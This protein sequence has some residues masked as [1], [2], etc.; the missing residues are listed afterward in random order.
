MNTTRATQQSDNSCPCLHYH[1][2]IHAGSVQ[3]AARHGPALSGDTYTGSYHSEGDLASQQPADNQGD[4]S[5]PEGWPVLLLQQ[6]GA[7]GTVLPEEGW[8]QLAGKCPCCPGRH[9]GGVR[10][11]PG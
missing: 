7:S 6:E 10:Q 11:R 2:D 4:G 8:I 3:L 9:Q 5:L 1:S